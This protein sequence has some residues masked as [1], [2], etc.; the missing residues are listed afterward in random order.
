MSAEHSP[1]HQNG[2]IKEGG[3]SFPDP[4]SFIEKHEVSQRND[5]PAEGQVEEQQFEEGN[6]EDIKE[7]EDEISTSHHHT[8]TNGKEITEEDIINNNPIMTVRT[9]GGK[10]ISVRPNQLIETF[11]RRQSANDSINN[12]IE[13][14]AAALSKQMSEANLAEAAVQIKTT[15]ALEHIA[16]MRNPQFDNLTTEEQDQEIIRAA[17]LIETTTSILERSQTQRA[18]ADYLQSVYRSLGE[19]MARN[20]V[21]WKLMPPEVRSEILSLSR[22]I[23]HGLKLETLGNIAPDVFKRGLDYERQLFLT[24]AEA[25]EAARRAK[26]VTMKQEKEIEHSAAM[27]KIAKET[28]AWEEAIKVGGEGIKTAVRE[29]ITTPIEKIAVDI[30]SKAIGEL[31]KHITG[32]IG[33]IK[34][35]LTNSED[36]AIHG[37]PG[38]FGKAWDSFTK[39]ISTRQVS[40]G[41][42]GAGV[43]MF[44]GIKVSYG[45]LVSTVGLEVPVLSNLVLYGLPSLATIAGFATGGVIAKNAPRWWHQLRHRGESVSNYYEEDENDSYGSRSATRTGYLPGFLNIRSGQGQPEEESSVDEWGH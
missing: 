6:F 23:A 35:I 14:T 15:L 16:R 41:F 31:R 5:T 3:M 12:V 24:R 34:Y 7:S 11:I 33:D 42:A 21:S 26:L 10:E 25:E 18:K 1:E 28:K 30:P 27:Q 8:I 38:A 17:N 22:D 36:G 20:I 43:A 9:P 45:L 19:A 44:Y 29:T 40:G 32:F 2:P 37:F 13:S 39:N 4:N